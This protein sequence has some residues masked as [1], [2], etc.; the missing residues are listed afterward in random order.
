MSSPCFL[1]TQLAYG[2]LLFQAQKG[3]ILWFYVHRTRKQIIRLSIGPQIIYKCLSS[4]SSVV[5]HTTT[6]L[7]LCLINALTGHNTCPSLVKRSLCYSQEERFFTKDTAPHQSSLS[8]R[9]FSNSFHVLGLIHWHFY[10]SSKLLDNIW[11][12]SFLT[13][14]HLSRYL[15]P[16]NQNVQPTQRVMPLFY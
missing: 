12:R 2:H 16:A 15:G 4:I 3:D 11:S 8:T 13:S 14:L 1:P 6:L 9:P 10:A 5:H 7:W